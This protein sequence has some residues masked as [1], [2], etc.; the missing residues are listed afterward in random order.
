M[1]PPSEVSSIQRIPYPPK[2]PEYLRTEEFA[3]GPRTVSVNEMTKIFSSQPILTFNGNYVSRL[4]PSPEVSLD[5][6]QI[7]K[8]A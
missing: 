8:S 7:Y 4:A 2:M 1:H 3:E 5:L 6:A